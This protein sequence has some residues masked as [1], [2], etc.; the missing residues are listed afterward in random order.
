MRRWHELPF[1]YEEN[2]LECRGNIDLLFQE[3]E[4][5]SLVDFKTDRLRNEDEFQWLLTEG[6][7]ERQLQQYG[8][9]VQRLLN[10]TPQLLL[11]L[12]DYEDGVKLHGVDNSSE[13]GPN[14]TDYE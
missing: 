4:G 14:S 2:G 12:L 9:A 7:Y 6:A 10:V 1:S 3:R 13:V 8:R 5:W 11:C